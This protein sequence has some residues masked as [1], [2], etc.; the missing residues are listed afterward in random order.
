MGHYWAGII[1]ERVLF[2]RLW[3]SGN[4][5][6]RN[7]AGVIVRVK[8]GHKLYCRILLLCHCLS[9]ICYG[10]T[11]LSGIIHKKMG[12]GHRSIFILRFE[13]SG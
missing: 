12:K 11:K 9:L 1:V 10:K 7:L 2:C 3:L 5:V 4:I 8:E 13:L 6:L